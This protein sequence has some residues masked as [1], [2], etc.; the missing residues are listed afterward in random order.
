MW[1]GRW[2]ISYNRIP[3][4]ALCYLLFLKHVVYKW[5]L[6]CTLNC[7][8]IILIY[9]TWHP[10]IFLDL[11]LLSFMGIF[12]RLINCKRGIIEF[13]CPICLSMAFKTVNRRGRKWCPAMWISVLMS[14]SVWVFLLCQQVPN[15]VP[16]SSH[17]WGC[18]CIRDTC[19]NVTSEVIFI[20]LNS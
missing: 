1:S 10:V 14:L 6:H 11:C 13:S 2:P 5:E 20:L 12:N 4:K 16:S 8:S 15:S 7:F 9:G 19:W 3:H 17:L 18:R